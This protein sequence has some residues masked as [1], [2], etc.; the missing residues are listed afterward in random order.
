MA[1]NSY[2]LLAVDLDGTLLDPQGRISAR[3]RS[4][5]H[6]AHQEGLQVVL[7]TGRTLPETL[8]V[9]AELGL[10]LDAVV[11][12][13]GAMISDPRSQE[14]LDRVDM[15]PDFA[16][17]MCSW[18]LQ[19]GATPLWFCDRQSAGHDG[20]V[21]RGERRHPAVDAW[22]ARTVCR[23]QERSSAPGDGTTAVR[24]SIIDEQETLAGL[25]LELEREW[26]S[27]ASYNLIRLPAHQ[28]SVI[29]TFAAG[30]D[31]WRAVEALCKRWDID[32]RMTLA[33]GDDMNDLSML[34][35]AGIGV[36]MANAAPAVLASANARTGSNA[37]DGVAVFVERLLDDSA[38][39]RH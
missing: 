30:V 15:I 25:H 35:N 17:R 24:I 9:L 12:C 26:S 29:E 3:N 31:K 14:T 2:R 33:I 13:S 18:F 20:F 22:C 39:A 4:S 34:R 28:I 21:I 23:V 7:C 32:P 6:R 27:R 8:P 5:L 10:D 16:R 37:E 11:T 1:E 19:R 36:A 38:A